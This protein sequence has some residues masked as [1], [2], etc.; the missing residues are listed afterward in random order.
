VSST[1]RAPRPEE[2]ELL[3]D[4]ERAAGA[5]FVEVGLADVAAH[6]PESV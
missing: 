5:L 1:I 2:L 4:I 6:E 3:R